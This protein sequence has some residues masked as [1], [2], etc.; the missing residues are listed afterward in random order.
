MSND[1][2]DRNIVIG[3]FILFFIYLAFVREKINI[4]Y[5]ISELKCN[6]LYLFMSSIILSN[7]DSNNNFQNCVNNITIDTLDNELTK[8]RKQQY[9]ITNKIT[10]FTNNISSANNQITTSISNI[11]SSFNNL[12]LDIADISN[13]QRTSNINMSNYY[14]DSNSKINQFTTRISDLMNNMSTYLPQIR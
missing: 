2:T 5:N 6:P 14:N 8:S 3:L 12:S 7:T 4:T 10:T 9:D 1:I 11:S 13:I